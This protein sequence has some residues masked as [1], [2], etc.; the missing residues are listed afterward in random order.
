MR[1]VTRATTK[2]MQ[3]SSNATLTERNLATGVTEYHPTLC[4]DGVG[5]AMGAD[6][7]LEYF[8]SFMLPADGLWSFAARMRRD[9]L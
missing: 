6:G 3:F 4:V 8:E 9:S 1:C 2:L 7:R 5:I